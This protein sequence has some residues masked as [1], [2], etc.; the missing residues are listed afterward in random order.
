MDSGFGDGQVN[1]WVTDVR[2]AIWILSGLCYPVIL[3]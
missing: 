2:V 3:K 1:Q